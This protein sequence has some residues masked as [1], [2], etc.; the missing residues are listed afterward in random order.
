MDHAIRFGRKFA[1][2]RCRGPD[3]ALMKILQVT[4]DR[5]KSVQPHAPNEYQA[6]LSASTL[7]EV[8]PNRYRAPVPRR[9]ARSSGL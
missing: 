1:E 5:G 7:R 2:G 8:S 9:L 6:L 3:Y 4:F